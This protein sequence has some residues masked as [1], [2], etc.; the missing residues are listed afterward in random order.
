LKTRAPSKLNLT[1]EVLGKREDGY[2]DLASIVQTVDLVDDVFIEAAAQRSVRFFDEQGRRLAA[3]NNELIGRAWDGLIAA[4]GIDDQAA[5]SVVKRIPQAA[6]LGG[7]SSDAAAFLRLARVWW[8]LG[9]EALTE[10]RALREVATA[11]GSDVP[12]FLRGG[13]LLLEGR[14]ER[15][16][17]LPDGAAEGAGTP[18]TALLFT[19][20]LPLPEAKTATVFGALRPS[21]YGEGGR[22]A[23]LQAALNGGAALSEALSRAEP[24]NTLDAVADEVLVGLR[25]ARRRM[26]AATGRVPLLAGAGPSLFVIGERAA[27]LAEAAALGRGLDGVWVVEAR[28]SRAARRVWGVAAEAIP[29]SDG[30]E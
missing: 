26:A 18:W 19:P 29:R 27:L 13:T 16:S 20:E 25:G 28:G 3:P 9:P 21:H 11:V 4:L 22:T 24:F 17:A 10:N 15:V 30:V 12:L 7:G 1:L 8:D 6:G 14:G 5:V 23:A 2:H